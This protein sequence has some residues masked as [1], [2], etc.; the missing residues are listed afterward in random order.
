[1]VDLVTWTLLFLARLVRVIEQ[2]VREEVSVV[3]YFLPVGNSFPFPFVVLI[4][5]TKKKKKKKKR[6]KTHTE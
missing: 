6:K 5:S 3:L 1:M 4:Y 2:V